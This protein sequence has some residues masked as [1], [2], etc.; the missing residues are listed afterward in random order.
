MHP[1]T[2]R[3]PPSCSNNWTSIPT[4]FHRCLTMMKYEASSSSEWVDG[5]RSCIFIWKDEVVHGLNLPAS[6]KGCRNGSPIVWTRSGDQSVQ[7]C[8]HQPWEVA[9][10]S[11]GGLGSSGELSLSIYLSVYLSLT[12]YLSLY[13]YLPI[14]LSLSLY[15]YSLIFI[16]AHTYTVIHR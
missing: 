15:I 11:G 9:G 16:D 2:D 6:V 8:M 1:W 7:G 12:I 3:R 14:Y 10:K 5:R 13:I 4:S